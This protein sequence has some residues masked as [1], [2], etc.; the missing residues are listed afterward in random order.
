MAA[1]DLNSAPYDGL[2]SYQQPRLRR[3]G[4]ENQKFISKKKQKIVCIASCITGE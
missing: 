3:Q 1:E 2:L 4:A